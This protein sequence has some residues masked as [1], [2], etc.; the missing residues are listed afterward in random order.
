MSEVRNREGAGERMLVAM[1][2]GVDSSVA[3]ACAREAG[4]EVV[5]VTMHLSGE[6]SRCCALEDVD[7]ARRVAAE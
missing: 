5:G 4:F 3:A 1:S 6:S 7:D 2:G